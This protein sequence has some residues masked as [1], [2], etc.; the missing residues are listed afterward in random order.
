MSHDLHRH[1]PARSGVR[2]A[3]G[4]VRSRS[5]RLRA[6]AEPR[7][8]ADIDGL[9]SLGV[10][11]DEILD[12]VLA[13]ALRC[14]LTKVVDGLGAQP[15]PE[16]NDVGLGLREALVVGRPIEDQNSV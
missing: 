10:P 8:G 9:R 15:D 5:H 14:F 2:H 7:H 16:Y 4:D 13:A 1:G 6:G 11:D 3:G 12:V